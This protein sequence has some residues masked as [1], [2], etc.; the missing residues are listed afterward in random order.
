MQQ[1]GTDFRAV[2]RE[3]SKEWVRVELLSSSPSGTEPNLKVTLLQGLPKASKWRPLYK[4][5]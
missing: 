2:I 5:V 1:S 4:S 3:M